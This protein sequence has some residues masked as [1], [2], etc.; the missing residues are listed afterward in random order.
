VY[1]VPNL[2][3]GTLRGVSDLEFH[4]VLRL[5]NLSFQF[6]TLIVV[7]ILQINCRSTQPE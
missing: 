1:H 3:A 6:L 7:S 5:Y 4:H 2:V